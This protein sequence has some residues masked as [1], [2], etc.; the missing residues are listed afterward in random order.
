MPVQPPLTIPMPE[1]SVCERAILSQ[2]ALA[3]GAG[4]EPVPDAGPEI[5][6]PGPTSMPT[7]PAA[8]PH[9]TGKRPCRTLSPA[10]RLRSENP[11]PPGPGWP[12]RGACATPRS[13]RR[14]RQQDRA[15]GRS[16]VDRLPDNL[17]GRLG[18]P[19]RIFPVV[20]SSRRS[21]VGPIAG[22]EKGRLAS[23]ARV[24]ETGRGLETAAAPSRVAALYLRPVLTGLRAPEAAYRSA[25]ERHQQRQDPR[26]RRDGAEALR[27]ILRDAGQGHTGEL[28][29]EA[30]AN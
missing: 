3:D 14:A 8:R 17:A 21:L 19:S 5:S 30:D 16:S 25:D 22:F 12:A 28:V 2:I 27:G 9:P 15:P 13:L 20:R 7:C 24:C 23:V 18:L 11:S 4:R 29:Y 6:T 26:D 1:V 10:S